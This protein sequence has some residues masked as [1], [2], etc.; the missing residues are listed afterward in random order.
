MIPSVGRD[1]D[2]QHEKTLF[3]LSEENKKLFLQKIED[4]TGLQEAYPHFPDFLY[5]GITE[6]MGFNCTELQM[7]IA[8]TLQ[9]GSHY[10]MIQAQRG[11]A[12]T[13]I[14]A[15]YA[16]WCMIHDPRFRVLIFSAGGSMADEISKWIIQIIEGWNILECLRPDKT[17]GDRT[18]T[19]AYDIHKWLK[20]AEKSPSVSCLGITSNMQGKRADLL[21]ADDIES[22]KNGLTELQREQLLH[23]TLDFTSIC[24]KGRII[25]LGTPQTSHSIYNTL[26][27]RNFDV[28]VWT[29]RFPTTEEEERY[30]GL[31]APW[32]VQKMTN[33]PSLR[34]GGGVTGDRGKPTDPILLDEDTLL[35][36]EIDQGK[37][38]F[39][40][41]HMLDTSLSDKDRYPLKTRDL[42]VMD[43]NPEVGVGSVTWM[44]DQKNLVSIPGLPSKTSLFYVY[45]KSTE[46]YPWGG[47]LMYVDPAGGGK[48]GDETAYAVT[49]FLH[50]NIYLMDA[51][52]L[53]GGFSTDKFEYLS[54]VAKK[55]GVHEIQVE[56]N[57][58]NGA[59]AQAWRPILKNYRDVRIEDVW[60]SG[61]KEL[62][63]IDVLE[64]VMARHSLVINTPVIE[65]DIKS[66]QH[67]PI[68]D[69]RIYQLLFQL[70]MITR[71]KNALRHDDRLD[72]V[73]GAVRPWVDRVHQDQQHMI[74]IK[75]E[76]EVQNFFAE[77]GGSGF[78]KQSNASA[79]D[80]YRRRQR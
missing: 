61:Q 64:P 15:F 27:A 18:R 16:V 63:I 57:F 14:T 71:D 9:Y 58:G 62:R 43:V 22:S 19:D 37:S 70:Q 52:G 1:I 60:E 26:P 34:T 68:Q 6:L 35:H 29:G 51:G 53:P 79:F 39:Q 41:Q 38:Y 65:K 31:L 23:K 66:T 28:K 69:R 56:K 25:Y 21:I 32:I 48:N 13:T 47:K 74:N 72:A 33:D 40:L 11:Q 78:N 46:T 5:D 54:E 30:D 42:I 49:Y 3:S 12:K 55:W 80:K 67:Y 36:K 75:R 50:G 76:D 73:A 44:P 7:D 2:K 17:L 10:L 4:L 77:W 24:S 59:F 45:S 20:G 8:S